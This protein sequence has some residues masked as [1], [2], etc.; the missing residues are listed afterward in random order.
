[1]T[2]ERWQTEWQARL[3]QLTESELILSGDVLNQ[4]SHYVI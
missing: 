3:H 1:M 4:S 2:W